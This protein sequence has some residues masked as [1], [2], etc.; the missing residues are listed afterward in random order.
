MNALLRWLASGLVRREPIQVH[1]WEP[2][3]PRV[4]KMRPSVP[5]ETYCLA[6]GRFTIRQTSQRQLTYGPGGS[7]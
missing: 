6:F 2:N 4:P 7:R 5:F 3:P 1:R